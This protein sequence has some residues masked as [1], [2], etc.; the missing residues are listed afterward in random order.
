MKDGELNF[1]IVTFTYFPQIIK[2]LIYYSDSV[3]Y[4]FEC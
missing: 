3:N 2:S 1:I 4:S